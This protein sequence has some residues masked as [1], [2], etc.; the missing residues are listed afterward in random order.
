LNSY[1]TVKNEAVIEEVIEKSRFIGYVKP[2]DNKEQAE[3]FIAEIKKK[4]RE[5]SHNVPVY[6]I[7]EKY[8]VQ[9]YSDDGEPSGT[10][11]LPVLKMLMNEGITNIA[12]VIT[13]YFGGVKLG[14]GGLVRAYTKTAKIA[15]ESAELIK[16][17]EYF[18]YLV[19][20]EY[21]LLGKMKND[22]SNKGYIIKDTIF[23]EQVKLIINILPSETEEFE[24][25]VDNNTN[26][27]GKLIFLENEYVGKKINA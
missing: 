4:N 11:G 2:V 18:K 19:E 10:A 15:I 13:R 24:K 27:K 25:M 22:I 26:G 14:T 12:I 16:V 5:A 17:E 7:G 6:L 21:N 8:E 1:K 23:E 9:K 3:L 20:I